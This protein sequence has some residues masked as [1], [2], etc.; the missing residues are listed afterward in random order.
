[1]HASRAALE[2]LHSLESIGTSS[3]AA[4]LLEHAG[5][6]EATAKAAPKEIVIIHHHTRES[7]WISSLLLLLSSATHTW[8][9]H[10]IIIE[11]VCERVPTPKE[12]PED[13]IS[14]SEAETRSSPA[15]E[16]PREEM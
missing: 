8:K 7:K 4:H 10:V 9:T 3:H 14:L 6:S 1:L 12:L 2:S 15:A 16:A 11:K 5:A 13:V